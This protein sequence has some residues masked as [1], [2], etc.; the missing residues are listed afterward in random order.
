MIS[1]QL[2]NKVNNLSNK[3]GV[4]IFRNQKGNI[5]YIGKASSLKKRV[6]NYFSRNV[7]D[8]R[9]ASMVAQIKNIETIELKSS[10]EALI[11][12]DRLVKEYQPKYNIDLKDGKKYPFIKVTVNELWPKIQ[13][14]R[15]KKDDGAKYFGPYT[16]VKAVRNTLKF[17]QKNF[18]LRRCKP[19]KP[20]E[21]D[22]KHCL[23]HHL[24]ECLAPCKKLTSPTAYQ[25]VVK[26]VSLFLEGRTNELLRKLSAK[27][28]NSSRHQNYEKAAKYR[29]LIYNL[30]EVV[31]TKIRK[32]IL[33]GNVYIANSI[34]NELEDLKNELSL[35]K[36]PVWIDAFDVSNIMGKHAVGSL[37]RFR[38]GMPF[39]N[40]YRKFKIKTVTG[41]DDY[42][43]MNEI[44]S[45]RY[46]K[47]EYPDLILID[48]GRGQLHA[49]QKVLPKNIKI[50]G[51]AKK[52][53]EL[54]LPDKI[55]PLRL[56]K[57]SP[58]LKL[59]MRIRD[60]AHRFAINYH[61]KLRSK[62]FK[63]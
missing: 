20:T 35:K 36:M 2:N 26:E 15:L 7:R 6:R 43:M 60:E 38:N 30:Q 12:E 18:Q 62:K 54:Y 32:K 14:V 51:L 58:A 17:L 21:K 3:P 46:K 4:Y 50:V 47:K 33:G 24:N 41:A 45:R 57:N 19:K 37:V 25:N 42:A 13:L 23:Y 8:P 27:M 44:V 10:A 63:T 49:A 16:D 22:L 59:L 9:I 39:K 53:E 5:L 31:G 48:G 56:P 1:K 34:E 52:F 40:G 11:L 55:S 28:R 29:D 61:R